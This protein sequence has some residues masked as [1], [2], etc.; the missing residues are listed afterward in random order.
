MEQIRGDQRRLGVVGED[1]GV[2]TLGG[3]DAL[4][5]FDVFQS[6]QKIAIGG[7]LF[8]EFFFGGGGH[9]GFEALHQVVAL[10]FEKEAGVAK[11]FGIALVGGE[12]FDARA[13]TA[14]YVVL[15]AGAW[16]IAGEIDV[17]RG[18]EKSFVNEVQ[19]A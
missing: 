14:L 9:A 4:A 3:G 11:G 13:Q 5:L 7:G 16:M 10:A 19:D 12:T 2:V 8:E 6:A 1:V 18:N 15:Q 17:A